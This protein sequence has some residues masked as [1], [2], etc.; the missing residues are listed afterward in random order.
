MYILI[1]VNMVGVIFV[2]FVLLLLYI[3]VFIVQFN[4]LQDGLILVVWV[5]WVS[6]NFIMG[7]SFIYM[8]V[9]FLLIIGFIYFYVVIMFNFVEVVD[10]MKKYGGF[11]LGIC[12]GCLMVEYFDYVFM[13]IMF[14]GLLY[15]GL[16][17]FILFIVFVMVGVNQ[18]FLFGGV[19]IFII[20]GVGFEIV[21]QIDVQLQQCYYEGFF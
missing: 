12:V 7:N 19:L 11:I 15:L 13:C 21:K 10:N 17:V 20:V 9:Y 14:F 4:I 3:L 16:I 18:N 2:I 6:V 8:V 1:K 5:I